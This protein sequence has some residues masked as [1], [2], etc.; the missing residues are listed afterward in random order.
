MQKY[1]PE[2][3]EPRT[4]WDK[5]SIEM[6][7]KR[8]GTSFLWTTMER[9][10]QKDLCREDPKRG[11]GMLKIIK[12]NRK[13]RKENEEL[14]MEN[15]ELHKAIEEA[16]R[17]LNDTDLTNKSIRIMSASIRLE[18][19]LK[20]DPEERP[21]KKDPNVKSILAFI[22]RQIWRKSNEKI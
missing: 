3:H 5:T 11:I 9:S 16:L 7:S 14:R 13:L 8:K 12:E 19:V 6:W 10:G 4:G 2:I 22:V 20:K 17:D 21:L 15:T 18:R 1:N